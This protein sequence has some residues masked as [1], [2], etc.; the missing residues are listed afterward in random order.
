MNKKY[1]IVVNSSGTTFKIQEIFYSLKD[2]LMNFLLT[3]LLGE[4]KFEE[5]CHWRYY[6][7]VYSLDVAKKEVE[8]LKKQDKDLEKSTWSVVDYDS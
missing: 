6:G 5:L 4:G 3:R 7:E 8:K 2:K 1:R